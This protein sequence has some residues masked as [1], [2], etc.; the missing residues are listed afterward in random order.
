MSFGH[1][2]LSVN[3]DSVKIHSANL[4]IQIFNYSAKVP[5]S[6]TPHITVVARF[7]DIRNSKPGK[8]LFN[9]SD[10]ESL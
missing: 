7:P 3:M 9:F 10:F 4:K 8:Q 6:K 5:I 2:S 1:I